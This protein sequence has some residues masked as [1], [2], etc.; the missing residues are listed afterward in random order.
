MSRLLIGR[1]TVWLGWYPG[2]RNMP[3][4]GWRGYW[5]RVN[6]PVDPERNGWSLGLGLGRLLLLLGPGWPRP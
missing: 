1:R 5:E 2:R 6:D 3:R 4:H